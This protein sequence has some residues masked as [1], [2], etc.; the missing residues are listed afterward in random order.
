MLVGVLSDTHGHFDTTRT[1]VERL[2]KHGAQQLLHCGDVGS[3]QV[4]DLLVGLPAG[5]VWGNCDHD[6]YALQRHAQV[7][8]ITC[9]GAVGRT[10]LDGRVF[11]ILH[12]DDHRRMRSLIEAQ[13][14]DFILSGHTHVKGTNDIGRIRMVNPGAI[15]RA[16][17]KTVAL[18]DTASREV[19]FV[20]VE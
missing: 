1:A 3:E 5:F 11:S 12:G 13:D 18:I 10:T 6:P 4:L 14:C 2:L 15:H 16:M 9:F 20:V 17:T 7:L 19:R 8:G